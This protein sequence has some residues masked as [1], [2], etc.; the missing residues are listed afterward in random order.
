[1][2]IDSYACMS[3]KRDLTNSLIT[4]YYIFIPFYTHPERD[5]EEFWEDTWTD[6]DEED[7]TPLYHKV[8]STLASPPF[9]NN[10]LFCG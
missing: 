2:V 1:M 6:S 4:E 7:V 8:K 3:I 9:N 5:S 10:P